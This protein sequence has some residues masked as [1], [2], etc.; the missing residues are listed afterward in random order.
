MEIPVFAY[1]TAFA[2]QPVFS[3]ILRILETSSNDLNVAK[4][5][6]FEIMVST[7]LTQKVPIVVQSE[8]VLKY[9]ELICEKFNLKGF[10]VVR[11]TMDYDVIH[12]AFRTHSPY[13]NDLMILK[14]LYIKKPLMGK[15]EVRY[16]NVRSYDKE[17][18]VIPPPEHL[19]MTSSLISALMLM[20]RSG[21]T[22]DNLI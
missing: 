21:L 10:S 22:Q 16:S 15:I 19:V 12:P 8:S 3:K 14:N 18:P 4:R 7:Y 6:V 13:L 9:L 2:S 20:N 1:D 5:T 11:V 17:N